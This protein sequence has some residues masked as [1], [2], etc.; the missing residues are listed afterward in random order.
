[1]MYYGI[2]AFAPF[3][4]FGFIFMILFWGLVVYGIILLIR[5]FSSSPKETTHRAMAVL[6][7]RYAKGD[8]TREEF[9]AIKKD[10]K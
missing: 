1:M 6:M 9:E 5:Q 3:H 10:I 4:M 2:D 7:E 8:I